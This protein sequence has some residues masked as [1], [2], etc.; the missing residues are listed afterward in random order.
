M[1]GDMVVLRGIVTMTSLK[2]LQVDDYQREELTPG[3]RK[4]IALALNTA[5]PLPS[6]ELGMRGHDYSELTSGVVEL[7]DPTF[8]IDG[9]QRRHTVMEYIT[10]HH[11]AKIRLGVTVYCDTTKEWERARFETLNLKRSKVAPSVLLRNYKESSPGVMALWQL[12]REERT[13]HMYS[14]I[15]WSQNMTR[16]EL[17]SARLFAQVALNLHAHKSGAGSNG[18][19]EINAG[20]NRLADVI[21]VENMQENVRRFWRL[22]DECWGIRKVHYRGRVTYL[23]GTFLLILA[24]YLSDHHDYWESTEDESVFFM[25]A[26]LRR[27]LIQFPIDDPEVVRL[28]GSAGM[29]RAMLYGLIRDHI[30]RGKT[31]KKLRS[32][33]ADGIHLDPEP[34]DCEVAAEAA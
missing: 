23:K 26:P 11:E 16:D 15:A 21:G 6:L 29:A 34:T 19:L 27:K 33:Y 31:T 14:R 5:Q 32:R 24:K 30:N 2:N 25:N 13:F 10:E 28:A 20:L 8:I 1:D 22:I 7:R 3:Q 18:V 17:L 12:S 9:Q 4:S